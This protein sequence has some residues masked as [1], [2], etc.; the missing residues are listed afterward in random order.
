MKPYPEYKESG[1]EWLGN[2]PEHWYTYKLKFLSSVQFSNV[3]KH[4]KEEENPVRLCNYTDVYYNDIISDKINFMNA[5]AN[6]TEIM[7]YGLRRGDVLITKDSEDWNDIAVPAYV[8]DDFD[9][10]LCGYHLAQIRP[11]EEIIHDKYLFYSFLSRGLNDQF[12][13]SANGITRYGL[14]KYWLDNGVFLVPTIPEQHAIAAFLDRETSRID[15]LIAKKQRQIELL[16]EK[17]SALISHV[18]TKG[19]DPNVKMKDSGVEW[20]GEVPEHWEVK[21]IRRVFNVINGSTPSSSNPEYWD[22]EINWVTP[23]DLGLLENNTIYETR[24]K[25]TVSGYE[26]CGT[27]LVP[28]G[29]IV[30]STRAPIGH[31]ALT[32]VPLCSNQ[33]CRLLALRNEQNNTKYFYYLLFVAR[34]K[35][36]GLGQGSTFKELSRTN[37]ENVEL[38]YPPIDE[39]SDIVRYLDEE[40]N[41]IDS[42]IKKIKISIEK[43]REYRTALISAAVTGKIDVREQIK[44][45][46]IRI[47]AEPGVEY[48]E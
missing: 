29:C 48:G 3:D 2:I 31:L 45:E 5:T 14:G 46:E 26:S 25:I 8:A 30:L 41:K 13:I 39:Q 32:G 27:T 9:N 40:C 36:E 35:L 33:G 6:V 15:T 24:R 34:P 44:D 18:V 42:L 4:T 12:R 28:V 43:L 22:G 47:A 16:Q 1:I 19:L 10:V 11:D 38:S 20:L 17:R 37:L 23:D 7:K 21:K